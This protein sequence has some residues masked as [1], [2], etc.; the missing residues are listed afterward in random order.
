[1]TSMLKKLGACSLVAI[2]AA[3]ATPAFAAG[4]VAGTDVTNTATISYE[5][6]GV[7]QTAT[8][9]PGTN[10]FKVDRKVN[11][12]V[13]EL[14]NATTNVT[15]GSL[16]NA[17][18]NVTSFTV[19][20][21]SNDTLDFLLASNQGVAAHGGTD[22][23]D[24][25]NMRI[26]VDTNN[27]GVLD[28]VEMTATNNYIDELAA[29]ASKNVFIV[30]DI[31]NNLANGAVSGITLTAT[32]ALGGTGGTAGA[33][34]TQTT[35]ANT[36][37]V[38]TV[39]ADTAGAVDAANDGKHS[40]RDD[41]T[42]VTA[43]LAVAK[44]NRIISDPYNNTTNPKAIPGAVIEYCIA[45]TN[46]G[47]ATATNVA[48]ADPLPT[49]VTGVASSGK[50]GG[51]GTATTCAYDG[52]DGGTVTATNASGTLTTVGAGTTSTFVFRATIK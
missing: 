39:F 27:N 7:T 17:T 44:Y 31:P 2:A 47:G 45:V 18:T 40:A 8:V 15:P 46:T 33:A 35:G 43:T 37:G 5:V 13:A 24:S 51:A 3:G 30:A 52:P 16:G 19:T 48:I 38:D 10:T 4:T 41:Y 22:T 14:G 34:L 42:V 1:M 23:F 26:Y 21:T 6:G 11:L 12:T 32:A 36:A 9:A 50:L 29:D 28:A 25:L 20:N 49:T